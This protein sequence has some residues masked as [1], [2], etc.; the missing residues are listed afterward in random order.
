MVDRKLA[1]EPIP[2]S[3]R[4]WIGKKQKMP[5]AWKVRRTSSTNSSFHR[6]L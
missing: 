1:A 3:L 6:V 4:Y 5:V 2:L